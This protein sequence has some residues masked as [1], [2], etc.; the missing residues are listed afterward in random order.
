MQRVAVARSLINDPEILLA[1]EPVGNLDSISAEQVMN[2]LFDVNKKGKKTVVLVTHDAKY[3]PYAHRVFYI[4][5][6]RLE[7]EVANPERPQL[8]RSAEKG[9]ITEVERLARIYPY[10]TPEDL[11]VKS[12]VNYLT[13][14]VTFEQLERLEKLV[15][16]VLTGRINEKDFYAALAQKYTDGGVGVSR[17]LSE[18]LTRKMRRLME[19]SLVVRRYRRKRGDGDDGAQQSYIDFLRK[20]LLEAYAGQVTHLQLERL[21][22]IIASRLSGI[23]QRD[24]F[25]QWLEKPL[26]E[27]GIGFETPWA[28]SM[29]V[30][31]EKL[32]AQGIKQ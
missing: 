18:V 27:G 25:Q 4:R 3:L 7:R 6:G 8:K 17:A 14:D 29:T 24:G 9:V 28:Q 19:E 10:D 16:L 20:S 13:Q 2:M 26:E 30:F 32:L 22:D 23:V 15:K 5:D 21:G 12:V 31:L 1:D 11:R